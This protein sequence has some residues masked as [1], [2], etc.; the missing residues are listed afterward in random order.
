MVTLTPPT[1]SL[2]A[3]RCSST[4]WEGPYLQL[5]SIPAAAK[6]STRGGTDL[7][8]Q[9]SGAVEVHS[10]VVSCDHFQ[11]TAGTQVVDSG[12]SA[13]PTTIWGGGAQLELA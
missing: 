2:A 4:S 9:I 1:P 6:P 10:E 11:C 8:A 5:R 7:G 3:A 13:I 12:G